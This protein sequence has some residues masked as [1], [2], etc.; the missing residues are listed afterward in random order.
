VIKYICIEG[1][2]GSGKTSLAKKLA[3]HF[4]A[5]F[6]GEEFEKNPFL[7]LFYENPTDY[8]FA[9]EFSFLLDRA[10]QLE[11]KK[12]ELGN[13]LHFSDY[14]IEKCLYF[15]RTNLADGQFEQFAKAYPSV[16]AIAPSPDLL[17][18]LHLGEEDLMKNIRSR[19]RSFEQRIRPEYL[20]RVNLQ[21]L[22]NSRK[23]R[24]YRVLNFHLN[25]TGAADY[26]TVFT[27]IT[28]YLQAPP[29]ASQLN[30]QIG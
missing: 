4:N 9:L 8:A 5:G 24:A 13:K 3:A 28:A 19:G 20:K 15:A 10:R 25:K 2:I 22:E 1:N 12:E 7:P 17:I 26:E 14:Y 29:S 30:I 18:F 6:I 11:E 16:A 21:Y 23:D 27:E